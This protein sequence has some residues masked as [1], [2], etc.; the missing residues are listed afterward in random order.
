[1]LFLLEFG[2]WWWFLFVCFSLVWVFFCSSFFLL[3]C[4]CYTVAIYKYRQPQVLADCTTTSMRELLSVLGSLNNS[5]FAFVQSRQVG[6]KQCWKWAKKSTSML[7]CCSAFCFALCYQ[8]GS[9]ILDLLQMLWAWAMA[10]LLDKNMVERKLIM[11]PGKHKPSPIHVPISVTWIYIEERVK[12]EK[13]A[14][15]LVH[16]LSWKSLTRWK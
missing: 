12:P 13:C 15:D 16:R 6:D 4:V 10:C 7:C 9:A 2:W 11:G 1:M 5:K 8:L 3:H 14:S